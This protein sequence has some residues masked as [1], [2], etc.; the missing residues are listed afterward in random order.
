M[1]FIAGESDGVDDGSEDGEECEGGEEELE[2]AAEAL[3]EAAEV[4]ETEAA[5]EEFVDK[6][7]E[8]QFC[9]E[10]NFMDE[11]GDEDTAGTAEHE[12]SKGKKRNSVQSLIFPFFF[13]FKYISLTFLPIN[14]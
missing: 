6:E 10:N 1:L 2:D 11:D 13:Q 8:S 14:F 9:L 12:D 3:T 4:G 5:V 7:N